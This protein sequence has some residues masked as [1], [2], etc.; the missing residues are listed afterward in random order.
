MSR[1]VLCA[2]LVL[3]LGGCTTLQKGTTVVKITQGDAG[4]VIPAPE[5]SEYGLYG[6]SDVKAIIA[7]YL[8]RGQ[9]I[10]F[11]RDGGKVVAVFGNEQKVLDEGSYYWN[12]R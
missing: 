5:D 7:P 9:S 3:V 1:C 10:G 11:R 8:K 12:R 4:S 6:W 2:A